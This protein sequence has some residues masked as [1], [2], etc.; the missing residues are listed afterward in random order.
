MIPKHKH[1]RHHGGDVYSP[2]TKIQL[3][4]TKGHALNDSV[5]TYDTLLM[6]AL[7]AAL[8]ILRSVSAGIKNALCSIKDRETTNHCDKS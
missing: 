7:N 2:Y 1:P 4:Q 5:S 3:F 6:P 8:A